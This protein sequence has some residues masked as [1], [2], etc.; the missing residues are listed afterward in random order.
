MRKRYL[1][2]FIIVILSFL[3]FSFE[4]N[5]QKRVITGV[6]VNADGN[7]IPSPTFQKTKG[8]TND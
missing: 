2:Q 4:A 7:D 3:L 5:A 6:V 8:D 1:L